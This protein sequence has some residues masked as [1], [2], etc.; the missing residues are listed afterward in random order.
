[1]P[2]YAVGDVQGCFASLQRLLDKIEFDPA[3]DR[4]WLAGDLVNRGPD[5]LSV[6]RYAKDLGERCICVLGNHDLH[7]LAT[8]TGARK[9][10]ARDT[11]SAILSAKDRVELLDWL[12]HRPLLHYD[13]RLNTALVHAGIAQEWDMESACQFARELETLLQS[14]AYPVFFGHMYGNKPKRWDAALSGWDRYRYFTNV[15]TR[16]RYYDRRGKLVLKDKGWPDR[17]PE[18][19]TPWFAMPQ[20]A[21]FDTRILFGHWATLPFRHGLEESHN[22]VHLDTGCVWRGCLTAYRLEDG[23]ETSVDCQDEGV[24]PAR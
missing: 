13:R 5:S 8:A 22:V 17:H 14:E 11:L 4:L 24:D 3:D 18:G 21:A 20:R 15:F 16:M 10:S 2:T 1:M 12:R 7:L 6:L 23:L 19:L 9:P